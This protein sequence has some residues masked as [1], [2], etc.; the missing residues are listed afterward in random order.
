[1]VLVSQRRYGLFGSNSKDW[2]TYGGR[3]LWH[4]N[5][6]EME[7]VTTGATVREIPRSTPDE[8]MMPLLSHPH[9]YGVTRIAKD[10]F[11]RPNRKATPA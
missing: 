4:H 3:I 6:A 5:A 2:L 9:F 10:Q 8:L 11:R 1:M 7:W